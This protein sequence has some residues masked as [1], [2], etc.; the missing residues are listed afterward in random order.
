M[1]FLSSLAFLLILG[2]TCE[3]KGPY[4]GHRPLTFD[5]LILND[6]PVINGP[7]YRLG[8]ILYIQEGATV[9][10][11]CK[12]DSAVLTKWVPRFKMA[13]EMET[14]WDLRADKTRLYFYN[15]DH[16]KFPKEDNFEQYQSTF[17]T[18]GFPLDNMVK[19]SS[20]LRYTARMEDN[21]KGIQCIADDLDADSKAAINGNAKLYLVVRPGPAPL[22]YRSTIVHKW[23]GGFVGQINI[24]ITEYYTSWKIIMKFNRNVF[25][26]HGGHFQVANEPCLHE[27]DCGDDRKNTWVIYNTFANRVLNPGDHLKLTFVA[28]VWKKI[29][30]GLIAD[31]DFYGYDQVFHTDANRGYFSSS[32]DI[33]VN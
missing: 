14:P 25:N 12:Q 1:S 2:C 8:R 27:R 22:A 26:L 5:R 29:D 20:T 13:W 15:I 7:S 17:T 23:R 11:L 33:H 16:N 31:V 24:P 10:I 19:F 9:D 18:D 4:G 28:H 32:S 3:A 30:Q 6:G 21:R